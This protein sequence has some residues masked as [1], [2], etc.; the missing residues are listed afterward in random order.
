MDCT[1]RP[2]GIH[3]DE[4]RYQIGVGGTL[5]ISEGKRD[6]ALCRFHISPNFIEQMPEV[7]CF[8]P[9]IRREIDWHFFSSGKLCW[10]YPPFWRE[11]MRLVA[12]ETDL[13]GTVAYAARW[14]MTATRSLLHKH[15]LGRELGLTKWSPAWTEWAHGEA[16]ARRQYEAYKNQVIHDF[17]LFRRFAA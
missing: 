7:Y 14:C 9:W 13:A 1:K 8:E 16:A 10:Q 11:W 3:F 5:L 6:S 15:R 4:S 12:S 17:P 2:G